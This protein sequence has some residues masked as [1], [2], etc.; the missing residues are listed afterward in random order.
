M[1]D[2]SK[3]MTMQVVA[4]SCH[5]CNRSPFKRGLSIDSRAYVIRH[6]THWP[7]RTPRPTYA[8]QDA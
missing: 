1:K 3:Q 6:H 5:L 8:N 7:I 2:I 4:A